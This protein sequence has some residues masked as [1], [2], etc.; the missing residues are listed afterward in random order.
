MTPYI[1]PAVEAARASPTTGDSM[2][3]V[4]VLEEGML[5]EVS[6]KLGEFEGV[7]IEREL[8]TD[9]LIADVAEPQLDAVLD[10]S[11]IQSASPDEQAEILV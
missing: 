1:H 8:D 11:G 5:S 2:T 10:V 3:V 9:T 6:R 7:D 4:F